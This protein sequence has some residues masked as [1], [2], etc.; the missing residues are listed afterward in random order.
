MLQD[1]IIAC[2]Y[3]ITSSK[4]PIDDALAL[5]AAS[6]LCRLP[7]S[8]LLVRLCLSSHPCR[9]CNFRYHSQRGMTS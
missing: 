1:C 2:T 8:A 5:A 4:S 7:C 3:S 9:R 6:L